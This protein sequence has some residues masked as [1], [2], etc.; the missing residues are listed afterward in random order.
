[1]VAVH[2]S[3]TDWVPAGY[4]FP[5]L[6]EIF[7]SAPKGKQRSTY[8][9]SAM[10]TCHQ[11]QSHHHPSATNDSF[12][13]A[14]VGCVRETQGPTQGPPTGCRQGE[15]VKGNSCQDRTTHIFTILGTASFLH[16]HSWRKSRGHLCESWLSLDG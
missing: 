12:V 14:S 3:F 5:T 9:L 11:L 4:S 2:E 13:H 6:S 8:C 7:N 10:R 15:S 1:M 16:T